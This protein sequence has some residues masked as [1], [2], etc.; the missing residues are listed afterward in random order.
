MA[1]IRADYQQGW[2]FPPTL[3]E[4]V[5]ADHPARFI[6]E[7]VDALDLEGLGFRPRENE[8]GR[9]NYAVDLLVRVWL[10]GY[11]MRIRSTRALE[12]A[13]YDNLGL[14]WLAGRHTPDHLTLWRFLRDHQAAL[15]QLF[16]E[17]V[18]LAV[19]SDLVGLALH[20]VDGTKIEAASAIATGLH[21][22]ALERALERAEEEA[23]AYVRDAER[24]EQEEYGEFRLPAELQ[25][26]EERKRRLRAALAE[27]ER[28]EREHKH[29]LEP[30]A[31]M[32][33]L[34]G[35]GVRFGYNAQ[36][37]ADEQSGLIVAQDVVVDETD[38]AQLTPMLEQVAAVVGQA[39][40]ETVA[41]GGYASGAQLSAA[42]AAGFAVTVPLPRQ[43]R[44]EHPY[45][46][47]RFDYAAEQ[48]TCRCPRGIALQFER[49]KR[50]GRTGETLQVF[51]CRMFRDCPVRTECS[52]DPRGRMV[53]IGP[54]RDALLRQMKKQEHAA[55][56]QKMRRRG[57]ISE[58]PFAGIKQHAQF[59]RWTLRHIRGVRT[60]WAL[61]CT[62]FNLT[63]LLPAWRAGRLALQT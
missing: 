9:P 8:V 6:R 19:K 13:C 40:A 41:D 14:L 54:H 29:P 18:R 33:K 56:R 24:S 61:I 57:V 23:A 7:V 52:R 1:E 25:D 42:E 47:S 31:R 55:V 5:P 17:V 37:V 20:A 12:R 48:N 43:C 11:M 30:E 63:K 28:E 60:Q 26:A 35:G 32:V 44:D 3:E 22:R 16:R 4:L 62:A 2:L 50:N 36:I 34:A 15:Q 49:V 58:T 27:L 21:K 10:Y 45:H 39:A 38:N 53:E 59:R 46:A 51:R